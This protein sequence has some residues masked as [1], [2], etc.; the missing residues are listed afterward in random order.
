MIRLAFELLAF[1]I[2]SELAF[3]VSFKHDLGMGTGEDETLTFFGALALLFRLELSAAAV[4]ED[5]WKKEKMERCLEL[6]VVESGLVAEDWVG[7]RVGRRVGVSSAMMKK[8][9]EMNEE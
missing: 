5:F 8:K 9:M 6:D 2:G 4:G 1:G 7:V 3:V